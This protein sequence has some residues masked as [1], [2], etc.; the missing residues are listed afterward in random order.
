ME[1]E[2]EASKAVAQQK[3]II[4]DAGARDRTFNEAFDHGALDTALDGLM[5][6]PQCPTNREKRPARAMGKQPAPN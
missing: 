4:K 5:V 6:Q 2:G 3:A 1:F